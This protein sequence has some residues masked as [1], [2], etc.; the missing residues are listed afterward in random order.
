MKVTKLALISLMALVFSANLM[1]ATSVSSA[2]GL[3][4]IGSVSASDMTTLEQLEYELAK[5]ADQAG[6]RYYQIISAG[7][8][9]KLHGVAVI[10]Q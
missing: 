1:A 6:A 8:D 4:K 9:N 5:K 10:Y 7:G 3:S 2:D